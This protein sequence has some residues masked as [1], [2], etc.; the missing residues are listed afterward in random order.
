MGDK[1]TVFYFRT[2]NYIK[3][4]FYFILFSLTV[5]ACSSDSEDE[6]DQIPQFD[7]SAILKNYADNIIIPRYNDLKSELDNLKT[8]VDNFTQTPNT[9]NFDKVHQK[10]LSTYIKWQHI[11]MFNIGKAEEIYYLNTIN[12]YP[13]DEVRINEN[14]NSERYD[15]NNSNDWSCQGLSGIDYMLHGT[16]NNKEEV[17]QKYINNPKY[18]DYL[19][20]LIVIMSRNTNDVVENWATYKSSFI[21]SSGNSNSS[22]L[23]MLTNDFVYYFEKD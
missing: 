3:N 15:L 14:I 11:E 18:A 19:K 1:P 4:I 23:N 21:Q 9:T 7:R 10:W 16:G 5:I 17:I 8:A 12:T 6:I 13:V 2:M 20:N 22:S